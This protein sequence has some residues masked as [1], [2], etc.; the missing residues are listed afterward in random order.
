VRIV[1]ITLRLDAGSLPVGYLVFESETRSVGQVNDLALYRVRPMFSGLAGIS[2]PPPSG[3]NV[4]TI[5]VSVDPDR[6]RSYDL[7]PQNVV[8]AIERG[9]YINPSGNVTIK[10]QMALVPA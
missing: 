9:S 4:R 6:L 1:S 3:G 8:D 5:V 10:D 7:S 2:S